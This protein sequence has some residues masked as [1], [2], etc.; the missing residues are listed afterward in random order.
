MTQGLM[1]VQKNSS[2]KTVQTGTQKDSSKAGHVIL[3]SLLSSLVFFL[4]TNLPFWYADLS[5]YSL[6]L[7]G[8]ITSYTMALPFFKNQIAGDLFF[9]G[10][11]FGSYYLIRKYSLK[12]INS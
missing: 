4:V 8:T 7:K 11:I 12:S 2:K 1:G 6:D 9:S 5:L 3:G 10:M